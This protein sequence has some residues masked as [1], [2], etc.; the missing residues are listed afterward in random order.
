MP[1]GSATD[2]LRLQHPSPQHHQQDD[3]ELN[4]D[5]LGEREINLR[6]IKRL[7]RQAVI[8]HHAAMA[9]A[10]PVTFDIVADVPDTI[11]T[12]VPEII[13]AR[14]RHHQDELP[15]PRQI[16]SEQEDQE[17]QEVEASHSS[18]IPFIFFKCI[19]FLA[20]FSSSFTTEDPR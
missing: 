6:I 1:E 20:I 14:P 17:R 5:G 13:E 19:E 7:D 8:A 16:R 2:F 10:S 15:Q 11:E 4:L 3:W 18:L 12:N 9:A